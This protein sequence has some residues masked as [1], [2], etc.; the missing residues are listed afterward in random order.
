M[1]G[2]FD[3]VDKFVGGV[4]DSWSPV[5]LTPLINIHSQLSQRIFKKIR[6]DPFGMLRGLGTLIHEEEKNWSRKSRVRLPLNNDPS[7]TAL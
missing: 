7:N 4:K 6:I 5:S 1:A 3:T 2:V